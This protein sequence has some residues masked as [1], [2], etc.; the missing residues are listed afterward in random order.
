LIKEVKKYPKQP[1]RFEKR[2]DKNDLKKKDDHRHPLNLTK[3][4]SMKNKLSPF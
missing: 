4:N 3:P 2:F 1:P